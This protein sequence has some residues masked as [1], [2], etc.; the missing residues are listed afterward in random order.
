MRLVVVSHK[1]CW[2]AQNADS[3]FATDGGFPLQMEAIS[4]LFEQTAIV[5]P[6]SNDPFPA[7]L[8]PLR[9]NSLHVFPLTVPKG[10]GLRRKVDMIRWFLQNGPSIWGQIRHADAVHAP[11][12]GDV[13]TIGMVF[14]LLQSKPLLVRH[15]G[16]WL[17]Q[18][19]AAERFWKWSMEYFAGGNNVMFA[20]G[21]AAGPPSDKNPNL[22]WIFST[23]LRAGQFE[24]GPP[25]T[26]P[27]DRGVR[28]IIA[29]R[30]EAGKGTDKVI[31]SLPAILAVFPNATLD[32]VGGGSLLPTLQRRVKDLGLQDHVTFH[33]RIEQRRVI[34]LLRQSHLF[35]YPTTASEG[36]PKVVLEALASGLPV[37]TTKVSVLPKLLESGAG[38]LLE[39]A[40][41]DHLARAVIEIAS[42][43]AA[44]SLMSTKAM[45]T[46]NEYSL[47]R[48]RDVIGDALQTAWNVRSLS[49]KQTDSNAVLEH[50]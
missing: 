4:E 25:R 12:P 27:S 24:K 29:C 17:V 45:E 30:Q 38:V 49:A 32:V 13:G 6:C 22:K 40:E 14:A 35:C 34:E 3:G 39:H 43:G 33:G 41:E 11:I 10:T 37:I 28:L 36:F 50:S 15:C 9:G 20:T 16:N 7:G 31:E 23:S 46:A 8:S 2:R 44:Y 1:L 47:E 5:V 19:T 26:L 42:D 18:K 21:G 48:W